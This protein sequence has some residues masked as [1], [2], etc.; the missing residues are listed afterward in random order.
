[1]ITWLCQ[2]QLILAVLELARHLDGGS[3]ELVRRSLFGARHLFGTH[4]TGQDEVFF[5]TAVWNFPFQ[6]KEILGGVLRHG[7]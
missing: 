5:E 6:Q 7:I 4:V 1:M 3:L 2:Y